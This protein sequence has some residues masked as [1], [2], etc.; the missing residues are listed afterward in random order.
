MSSKK[1][2]V[3]LMA[4]FLFMGT[5]IQAQDPWQSEGGQVGSSKTNWFDGWYE[6]AEGY[7][8]A[9]AEY[10]KTN[11]P[12]VVYVEVGW[13]PYCRKF[14]KEV[15]SDPRVAAFMKD[16]IKVRVDPEKSE[17]AN[18]IAFQYGVMGFPSFFVHP[19]QPGGTVR[20]YTGVSPL[21]FIDFFKQVIES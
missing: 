11:K 14:E 3:F 20:L 16:M 4:A 15:L 9:V 12:M 8:L 10:E 21:Q 18:V 2:L 5:G 6:G 7:T 17:R 19:P 13:C 1:G